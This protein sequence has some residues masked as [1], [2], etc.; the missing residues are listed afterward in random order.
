MASLPAKSQTSPKSQVKQLRE[1]QK[2][3]KMA[4]LKS[5]IGF[6]SSNTGEYLTM[7]QTPLSQPK[8][9]VAS[10]YAQQPPS[11]VRL[12]SASTFVATKTT[13]ESWKPE[14]YLGDSTYVKYN[15]NQLNIK[16]GQ[17]ISAE[18]RYQPISW[19][20]G[21]AVALPRAQP[22]DLLNTDTTFPRDSTLDGTHT[23]SQ[24]EKHLLPVHDPYWAR[25]REAARSY[26]SYRMIRDDKMAR[27]V[28]QFHPE[29]K[30][31][32]PPTTQSEYGWGIVDKY[33]QAC[34]KYTPGALWAGRKAGDISKFSQRMLLGAQHHLSG[35][36]T[37]PGFYP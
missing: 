12:D 33:G 36:M 25:N 27:R 8:S 3:R 24:T 32:L 21:S 14:M 19:Q 6:A 20:V 7:S 31:H 28:S 35:P 29:E 16:L 26:Q 17:E 22:I 37:Q 13:G 2:A 15:P 4:N 30:Y 23:A 9:R 11:R 34:A 1:E 5:S 18:E 10:M